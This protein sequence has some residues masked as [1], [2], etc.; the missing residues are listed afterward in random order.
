MRKFLALATTAPLALAACT[1]GPDYDPPRLE[2]PANF[3]E[4][5][6]AVGSDVDPAHWWT[7]FGDAELDSLIERALDGSPSIAVAASRIRQARTEEI[8]ARAVGKPTVNATGNVSHLEFS[9]NA[10]LSSLARAFGGGSGDQSGGSTGNGSSPST[11]IALPGS[12]ITTYAVGFDAQWEL[13]LFGGGQRGA[14]AAVAATEAQLWN[15]R[16]AAVTLV[17]EIADAYFALRMDRQQIAILNE[18][19]ASQERAIEIPN[20]NAQVGLSPEIDVVRQRESLTQLR[21]RVPQLEADARVRVHALGILIGKGPNAVSGELAGPLPELAPV[22]AVPAGLPSDLLR[23]RPDIRAAERNLAASTAQVGV[24]VADL[25]PKFS[26]TGI[27]E[28]ISTS[29][30]SLFSTD[31]VQL[32]GTAAAMFPVLDWGTRKATVASREEDRT[33]AYYQYQM[34][35]LQGLK[36]VEDALANIAAERQRNAALRSGVADAMRSESA[37]EAQY[38]TGLVSQSPLLDA[39]ARV[40]QAR[41]NLVASDAQLRQQTAALF[42]AL[43]GGWSEDTIDVNRGRGEPMAEPSQQASEG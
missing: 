2:V 11:G 36:D 9:K 34:T 15:A 17:A 14:E 37:V 39:Q 6:P 35:V 38:R 29:L 23:R 13:D 42:K 18:E 20:H 3:A 30:S 16:D 24:A 28:L 40:L 4:P 26:L 19:I 8:R 12:G 5:A 21:A 22:P 27:A 31:S 25:Y 32:Q 1:V 10:G 43:G 33:Q 41:E 7:A